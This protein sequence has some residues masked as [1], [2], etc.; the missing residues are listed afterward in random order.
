MA[1]R[2]EDEL[3]L[4]GDTDPPIDQRAEH[5][6]KQG[7]GRLI[8]ALSRPGLRHAVNCQRNRRCGNGALASDAVVRMV[9]AKSQ[10]HARLRAEETAMFRPALTALLAVPVIATSAISAMADPVAD[11]YRGRTIQ[12]VI[13]VSAGGDYDLRAR[14]LAR[15]LSKHIPGNPKIVPQ[16]MLGAGGLVAANWLANVAPRDGTA[17]LAI[18]SNLPVAQA[19]GLEGVKYDVRK[20][21]YLGNTTD[22]P[23][24]INSWHTTGVT[25]IEQ[26]MKKEFVVGATGR[27]SGSYYYPAAL[28]AYAGTKFKIVFGYPGGANVNIAMERGEVGGRGS[29][30]WASWKST[31]PH[32]LADKKIHML[33]QIALKRHPELKDVPLMQELVKNDLHKQVLTFISAD[34]AIARSIVTTPDV[35]AE[36]VAALRAAFDAAIKDPE[37]LKEAAQA[38]QD[39]SPSSGAEAQK[40]ANSIVDTSPE[41]IA[42]AKKVL[43][44]K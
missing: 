37:L 25:R 13:G 35:P 36:R 18:S 43:I 3:R 39:I 42:E 14:L 38:K 8:H 24:V 41:V 26:V 31:R 27:S 11:F 28:N 17:M 4:A 40:I 34:T 30:L 10:I 44:S 32:W 2:L 33:V 23:N 9:R 7:L 1:E 12:M 21:S 6:E 22:S 19:I 20:F 5:V 29:N 15:F 16:N